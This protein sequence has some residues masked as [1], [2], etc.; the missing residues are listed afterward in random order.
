MSDQNIFDSLDPEVMERVGTRRDALFGLGKLGGGLALASLPLGLAAMAKKAFA[1]GGLPQQIVDV[2]NFALTLEYLEAEFYT[3]GV[4][5]ASLFPTPQLR[6]VFAIIRDHELAHVEFLQNALGQEAVPKPR[7]DFTAGGMFPDVFSNF[8]T[9]ATLSQ[10]FEDTGV[11]AYK[12]QVPMLI[13]ND[14]ILTAALTIHSVEARHASKVRR[15][16]ASPAQ[17]GWIPF[18]PPGAIAPLVP[19]YQGEAETVQ[20]GIRM[21]TVVPSTVSEEDITEAF[22]E[23][24][25]K[26]QILAIVRPFIVS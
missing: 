8:A 22:D 9:F 20:A 12:G 7:F 13:N 1:Q 26:E 4:A 3:L 19:I 14:A 11:R 25:P 17:Q 5:N 16:A 6:Q 18:A 2:L 24:L 10:G 23:P 15:L 21:T